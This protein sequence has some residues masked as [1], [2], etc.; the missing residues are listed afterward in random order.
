MPILSITTS[1]ARGIKRMK[2]GC[3]LVKL[4]YFLI[5]S[6]RISSSPFL[7]GCFCVLLMGF[8]FCFQ[9]FVLDGSSAQ[10]SGYKSALLGV[11][12]GHGYAGNLG[13]GQRFKEQFLV[14]GY[15]SLRTWSR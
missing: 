8:F 13:N 6:R 7:G 14:L 12:H 5:S 2:S 1:M 4:S 10:I 9:S 3:F 11:E 15:G